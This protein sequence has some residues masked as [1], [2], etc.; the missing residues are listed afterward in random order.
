MNRARTIL[1]LISFLFYYTNSPGRPANIHNGYKPLSLPVAGPAAIFTNIY[2]DDDFQLSD[3]ELGITHFISITDA[4]EA[5]SAGDMINIHDGS[6]PEEVNISIP[7][8]LLAVPGEY[9][10]LDGTGL[11]NSTAITVTSTGVA[12]EGLII[13]D[14]STGILVTTT[15]NA[16]VSGC[17]VFD[18]LFSGI[19]NENINTQVLA[20]NCWW[21]SSSGPF[22]PSDDRANGGLYN[23]D[24]LGNPVSDRIM[25]Y[26]WSVN[27][28]FTQLPVEFGIYNTTCKTL[29]VRIKPLSA[30]QSSTTMMSFTVRW[31]GG[32]TALENISSPTFNV[33]LENLVTNVNGYNYAVFGSDNFTGI[34]C[35]AGTEIPVLTFEHDGSGNGFGDFEI[36]IDNWTVANNANP[37]IELMGTDYSGGIN[38]KA[39]N[40]YLDECANADIG[41]FGPPAPDELVIKIRPDHDIPGYGLTNIQFT[42]RWPETSSVY[43][44]WPTVNTINSA[45]NIQPQGPVTLADGYYH[46]IF[47]AANN[48]LLNWAANT[49]YP[50]LVVKYYYTTGDCTNFE[51]TNDSWTIANN[52]TYFFEVFGK[53]Q[54]GIIYEPVVQIVSEGG[55]IEGGQEI[56]LGTSTGIMMLINYSG[57]IN[58]WEKRYNMGSW[59]DIPGTAGL[60]SYSEVPQAPGIYEY[61]VEVQ[62]F[63][64]TPGYSE[65]ALIEVVQHVVWTGNVDSD[66]DDP[67]NWNSCGIPVSSRDVLIPDVTPNPFPYVTVS[68]YCNS[69]TILPGATVTV[70]PQGSVTVGNNNSE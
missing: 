39:E 9:P 47:S 7:V 4:L 56:C 45:F 25:Y 20:T 12:I 66:W 26:P 10:V 55:N 52:G 70:S 63:G 42:I 23:P 15:G 11:S 5:A 36:V 28:T 44:L 40:V 37:Y 61:R 32:P 3:P 21:G 6:Y 17:Q 43:Q 30:I 46:Q 41:I 51:I 2:V 16:E 22:D 13:K 54:T 62:K 57:T 49:E 29:E 65:P 58:K 19:V 8:S 68:G 59:T 1:I 53:D 31:F 38:H 67:E 48:T 27:N 33:S 35:P 34:D 18:N 60:T 69:I 14:Y 64:C 50:V 24:G